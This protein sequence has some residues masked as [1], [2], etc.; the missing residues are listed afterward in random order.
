MQTIIDGNGRRTGF[1]SAMLELFF[2]HLGGIRDLAR[3]A[4]VS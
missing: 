1:A 4:V 3:T 2:D